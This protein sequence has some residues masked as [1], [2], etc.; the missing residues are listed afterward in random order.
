MFIGGDSEIVSSFQKP[1]RR[2]PVT[3]RTSC[4]DRGWKRAGIFFLKV[5]CSQVGPAVRLI[6][7]GTAKVPMATMTALGVPG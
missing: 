1:H 3:D 5:K 4:S 6:S 7:Q 2:I